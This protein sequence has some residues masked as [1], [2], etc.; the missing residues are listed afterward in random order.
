MI[1][2][3]KTPQLFI[4]IILLVCSSAITS[5]S[6]IPKIQ[7]GWFSIEVQDILNI[8]IL[9]LS[10]LFMVNGHII[11][12]NNIDN[13]ILAFSLTAAFGFAIA[14]YH[15]VSYL[16]SLRQLFIVF[17]IPASYYVT[18]GLVKNEELRSLSLIRSLLWVGSISSVLIILQYIVS[19]SGRNLY[20]VSSNAVFQRTD[21]LLII[22]TPAQGL[23]LVSTIIWFIGILLYWNRLSTLVFPRP[24]II[25]ASLTIAGFILQFA[26]HAFFGFLCALILGVIFSKVK[27]IRKLIIIAVTVIVMASLLSILSI[28]SKR[29]LIGTFTPQGILEDSSAQWRIIELQYALKAFSSSPILGIGLGADYR[30]PIFTDI[31]DKFGWEGTNY[32]HNALAWWILDTGLIGLLI[33]VCIFIYLIRIIARRKGNDF[34]ISCALLGHMAASFSSPSWMASSA[35]GIVIGILLGVLATIHKKERYFFTMD[36]FVNSKATTPC[37]YSH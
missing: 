14:I 15:G 33:T 26:R 31:S 29:W 27:P 4:G 3:I 24:K 34:L 25:I 30:P 23:L 7:A 20:L 22:R 13:I 12:W 5:A 6:Y 32:V 10:I 8:A 17:S 37:K 21:T 1:P 11:A 19:Y 9:L 28:G 35:D 16:I 2:S 36:K 18:R